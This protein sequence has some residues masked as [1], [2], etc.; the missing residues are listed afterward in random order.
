MTDWTP[1][2]A[3]L[4]ALSDDEWRRVEETFCGRLL[5]YAQRRTGDLQAAED[6]VQETLLGALR[7]IADFDPTYSFE[8]FLFG[9]CRNRTIDHMRRR[10]ARTIQAP[11]DEERSIGIETLAQE[12]ETPSA[13]VRGRELSSR[14][15]ELFAETLK[16]WVEETWR[17]AEFQRL[18]VMEALLSGGWRNR[19]AWRRFELRDET[20]VAGIKFRALKRM[21]ELAAVRESGNDLLRWLAA[22][23][24][25]DKGLLDMDVRRVWQER[26]VSCPSRHWLARLGEGTLAAGPTAFVRFHLDEMKCPWCQA[27]V[28]D[29]A[30][31]A[32]HADRNALVERVRETT[33]RFLR[34]DR[35]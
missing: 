13:I 33:Q 22:A 4:K 2:I 17:E 11:E 31:Q 7:G 28:D 1:D 18:C 26:R 10:K 5:A 14:A 12:G 9:I 20:A 8:Q 30:E 35:R 29:L 3:R 34:S 25:D 24:D 15:R 6:V 21:R 27:N 23:A 16:E 19:D 32:L